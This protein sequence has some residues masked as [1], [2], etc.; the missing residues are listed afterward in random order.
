MIL[1]IRINSLMLFRNTGK[2]SGRR[3]GI[4]LEKKRKIILLFSWSWIWFFNLR[5]KSRK[6]FKSGVRGIGIR[7]AVFM[8]LFSWKIMN[9]LL[10]FL[11]WSILKLLSMHLQDRNGFNWILVLFLLVLK[12]YSYFSPQWNLQSFSSPFKK[13]K[14][15]SSKIIKLF[16]IINFS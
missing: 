12:I 3:M 8:S 11:E 7:S 9:S 14:N 10:F 2:S 1:F 16:T 15:I 4:L 13:S 6:R 5:L